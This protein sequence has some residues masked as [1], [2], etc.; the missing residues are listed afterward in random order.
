MAKF[1][2]IVHLPHSPGPEGLTQEGP[3]YIREVLSE[4]YVHYTAKQSLSV[5]KKNPGRAGG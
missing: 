3:H 4:S 2:G 1:T 5:H